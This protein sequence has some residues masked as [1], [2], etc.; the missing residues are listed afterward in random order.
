[1]LAA[2]AIC[3]L[4]GR[5]LPFAKMGGP[6]RRSRR[7]LLVLVAKADAAFDVRSR[8]GARSD[9]FEIHGGGL[10]VLAAFEVETDLLVLGEV[11]QTRALNG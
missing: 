6:V 11:A 7:R 5:R 8:Q 2:A 3:M 1:M 10:A 4:F 9:R